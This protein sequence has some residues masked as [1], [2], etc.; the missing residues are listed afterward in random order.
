MRTALLALVACGPAD[1][2]DTLA[3]CEGGDAPS[4]SLGEGG[5]A[6]FVPWEDGVEVP[7]VDQGGLGIAFQLLSTGLDTSAPVSAVIRMA[8]DGNQGDSIASLSLQCPSEGPGWISAFATLPAAEQSHD[9]AY[10]D[11]VPATVHATATDQ[12]G[13]AASTDD[14]SVTLVA[15]TASNSP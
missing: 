3:Q 15:P 5:L 4:L 7:V 9:A 13:V 10:F 6:A 11:G 12:R 1:P 2:E 14:V 8:V